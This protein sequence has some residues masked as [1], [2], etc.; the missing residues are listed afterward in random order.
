MGNLILNSLEIRRFRTFEDL[1]LEHLGQVNLVVGKKCSIKLKQ[2]GGA[3][4]L[5]FKMKQT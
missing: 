4:K 1:Q 3:Q 2:A 5:H